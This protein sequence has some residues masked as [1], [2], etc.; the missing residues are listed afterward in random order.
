MLVVSEDE[1]AILWGDLAVHPAQVAEPDWR[2]AADMDA[3]AARQ[4]RHRL[5]D[6]IETEGMTVAARHFPAPGFGQLVRVE[7]RR[8]WHGL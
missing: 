5:L 3:D 8:Y 1:R 2:F 4:T 7:G 6:R